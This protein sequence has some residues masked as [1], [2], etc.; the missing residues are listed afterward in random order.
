ML[1]VGVRLNDQVLLCE[2]EGD[3][4]IDGDLDEL[5]EAL[6]LGVPEWDGDREDDDVGVVERLVLAESDCV[7]VW[8]KDDDMEF[9]GV[10]DIEG[11]RVVVDDGV[12]LKDGDALILSVPDPL[13][14]TELV[15]EGDVEGLIEMVALGD[16]DD[17]GLQLPVGL[18]VPLTLAEV[19]ADD[20]DVD[21]LVGDNDTVGET[22][23]DGE[24]EGLDDG[25]ADALGLRLRLEETEKL[26]D[27]VWVGMCVAVNDTDPLRDA[28]ELPDEEELALDDRDAVDVGVADG[29]AECESDG[30]D[31]VWDGVG[32]P[33]GDVESVLEE[34]MESEQLTELE[35]ERLWVPLSG[36]VREELGDAEKLG[37]VDTLGVSLRD[38][39][40]DNDTEADVELLGEWEL[41]PDMDELC[42]IVRDALLVP[43]RVSEDERE[44]ASLEVGDVVREVDADPVLEMERV[45][46][47][48]DVRELLSW[49][50]CVVDRDGVGVRDMVAETPSLLELVNDAV[51]VGVTSWLSLADNDGVRRMVL[52]SVTSSEPLSVGVGVRIC[53]GLIV[54]M[55]EVLNETF[56]ELDSSS[57][58]VRVGDEW[59]SDSEMVPERVWSLE[60][61]TVWAAE[62]NKRHSFVIRSGETHVSD[63][64]STTATDTWCGRRVVVVRAVANLDRFIV[65]HSLR[66]SPH[67]RFGFLLLVVA[68][69]D[70]AR[71]F[72]PT[73]WYKKITSKT[74]TISLMPHRTH[75]SGDVDNIDS[76]SLFGTSKQQLSWDT[77]KTHAFSSCFWVGWR[78]HVEGFLGLSY[79]ILS[80]TTREEKQQQPNT[81]ICNS[82]CRSIKP[83][84]NYTSNL[85]IQKK[86]GK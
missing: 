23:A 84:E 68:I 19:D 67:A 86:R 27:L 34:L 22:E 52:V 15:N 58:S 80:E 20:D 70:L 29:V 60:N 1:P 56:V 50:E 5:G 61:V 37:E 74:N 81:L 25:V 65:W 31:D 32:E 17:D 54:R 71:L 46:E 64:K 76:I 6:P 69:T 14:D 57:V 2:A 72:F 28:D 4:E 8:D 62:A 35:N 36:G 79:F 45:W 48:E 33:D 73:I 30:P 40:D 51:A 49:A 21:V 66:L 75:F 83:P 41:E 18:G 38:C 78:P 9:V 13:G 63:R 7:R 47:W 77:A 39:E 3:E 44:R 10:D 42:S 43:E 11:E 53:V 59:L 16:D 55:S 26:R 12:A 85:K 82:C 24:P